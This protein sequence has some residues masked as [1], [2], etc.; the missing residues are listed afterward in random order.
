M[1]NYDE[2]KKIEIKNCI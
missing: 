1:P 2:L